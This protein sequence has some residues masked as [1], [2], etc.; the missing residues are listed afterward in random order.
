MAR[1]A[2]MFVFRTIVL[3]PGET[4]N[5]YTGSSWTK[6]DFK[7]NFDFP[8]F[9]DEHEAS[10]FLIV[11]NLTNLL[12]DDWGVLYQHNFPRTI[13]AGTAESRLGDASRYEIRFGVQYS[14]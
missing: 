2:M 11:D 13:G 5:S 12:N 1:E 8:G 4:R 9:G 6:V 7:A 10:V 3:E 14:F